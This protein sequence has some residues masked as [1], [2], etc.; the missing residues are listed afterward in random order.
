MLRPP[1]RGV[2]M[3]DTHTSEKNPRLGVAVS[4]VRVHFAHGCAGTCD[5]QPK[6]PFT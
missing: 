2:R 3:R 6:R 4:F 1:V 5:L